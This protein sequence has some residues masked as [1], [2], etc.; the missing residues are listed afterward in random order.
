M[1]TVDL[2]MYSM[3]SGS[4]DIQCVQWVWCTVG[5]VIYSVY[6]VYGGSG[7]VQHVQWVW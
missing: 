1:C 7:D 5:L 6:S 2:V 4:G 3:Y